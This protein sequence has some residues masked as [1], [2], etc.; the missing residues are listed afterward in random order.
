MHFLICELNCVF[1]NT[2]CFEILK[3][4]CFYSFTHH[5]SDDDSVFRGVQL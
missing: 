1:F 4:A 3:V 5:F 2:V